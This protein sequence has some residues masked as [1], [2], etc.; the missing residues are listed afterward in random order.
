MR[1]LERNAPSNTTVRMQ[2]NGSI[3]RG[4]RAT[5]TKYPVAAMTSVERTAARVSAINSA[6]VTYRHQP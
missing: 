5:G 3:V 1:Q 2:S 4:G 6:K